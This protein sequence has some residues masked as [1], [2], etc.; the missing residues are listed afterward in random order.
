MDLW[1]LDKNFETLSVIDTYESFI[2]TTRYYGYGDFE[3]IMPAQLA[4]REI[5]KKNNYVSI[6][7]K[8]KRELLNVPEVCSDYESWSRL[9]IIET[10]ETVTDSEDGDKVTV[11]GRSL[12]SIL[13]RRVIWDAYYATNDELSSFAWLLL[14]YN[15][16]DPM[17]RGRKIPDL[18][19]RERFS[20]EIRIGDVCYWG[21]NLYEVLYD[22]FVEKE[23]GFDILLLD[24]PSSSE[25]K[26]YLYFDF[27]EGVDRSYRQNERPY[28]VFS[29]KYDNFLSSKSVESDVD[30]KTACRVLGETVTP[31]TAENTMSNIDY[32]TD[33]DMLSLFDDYSSYSID[34]STRDSSNE[35]LE[36]YNTVR[37]SGSYEG[38]ESGLDRR[39]MCIESSTTSQVQ[40]ASGESVQMSEYEYIQVLYDEAKTE[41]GKHKTTSAY[42]GEIQAEIQFVLGRDFDLGDIVQAV[43][44]Y[45]TQSRARVVEIVYSFDSQGKKIY[46]TFMSLKEDE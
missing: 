8:E 2:W 14:N 4:D 12:S 36:R 39:E 29:P 25:V 30:L 17:N 15:A 38:E 34:Q 32:T 10:I 23:V 16:I 31:N 22:K 7:Q 11:T 21:E 5:I 6:R 35:A 28:V 43:N 3:L 42:E 46:P 27:Y 19:C 45:G 13:D 33:Q 9:M 18:K 41:L 20:T 1:I 26:H 44:G 37:R 40:T 24:M